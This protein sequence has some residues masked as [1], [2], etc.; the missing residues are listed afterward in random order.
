MTSYVAMSKSE[1]VAP[2][3]PKRDPFFTVKEKVQAQTSQL[4]ED[5]VVWRDLLEN[6]NTYT[7]DDFAPLT[8]KIRA[9]IKSIDLGIQD[10]AKTIQI[11]EGNRSRFKNIDD[12]ELAS[13]NKFV[14][15]IRLMLEQIREELD[16]ERTK[17]KMDADARAA[18]SE[19]SR[20]KAGERQGAALLHQEAQSHQRHQEQ[21]DE[22]LDDMSAA[23]SRLSDVSENIGSELNT[24]HG[25]LGEMDDGLTQAQDNMGVVLR[26]MDKLIKRS[27]KGLWLCMLFLSI[28]AFVLLILI[29]Y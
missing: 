11:V 2:K 23:L 10:L 18:M 3:L 26:K 4:N 29:I 24:H 9:M 17:R 5:M 15:E 14:N 13:R 8:G 1:Q 6:H 19:A 20:R 7:K 28:T 16:G 12:I 27:D 22:V 25:L 21:Q